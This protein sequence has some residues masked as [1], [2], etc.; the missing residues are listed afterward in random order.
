MKTS[1]L[2]NAQ[3]RVAEQIEELLEDM[4]NVSCATL[5]EQQLHMRALR[6]RRRQRDTLQR[7]IRDRL[8][9]PWTD[10]SRISLQ[11]YLAA[12]REFSRAATD[13]DNIR[14]REE[15]R[16]YAVDVVN[17]LRFAHSSEV[18]A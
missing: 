12:S 15:C 3:C 14:L 6:R 2:F 7:V 17:T 11:R 1:T 8:A 5:R 9:S 10:A 18:Q 4:Q 13:K 16:S